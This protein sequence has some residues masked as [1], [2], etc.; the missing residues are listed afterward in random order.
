MKGDTMKKFE[1]YLVLILLVLV[2]VEG[3]SF[4]YLKISFLLGVPSEWWVGLVTAVLGALSAWGL[5]EWIERV[6]TDA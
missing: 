5:F 3:F 4:I 1:R 2:V 6:V